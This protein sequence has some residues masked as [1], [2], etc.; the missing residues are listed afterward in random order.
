[1]DVD[2]FILEYR[3]TKHSGFTIRYLTLV[4]WNGLATSI[5][6]AEH[7]GLFKKRLNNCFLSEKI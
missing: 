2:N 1:M 5:T 7:T 4:I 3:D 6:K